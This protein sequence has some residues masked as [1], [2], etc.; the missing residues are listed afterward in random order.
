MSIYLEQ[1][2]LQK[3]NGLARET[4]ALL[5]DDKAAKQY[6]AASEGSAYID[7]AEKSADIS[8]TPEKY[9][10]LSLK[11][12]RSGMFEKCI[13]ACEKALQ[14]RP[15]FAEAYNNI[16]S[17]HNEMKNW[18]KAIEAC[19]KALEI[20]PEF[21]LARNNLQLAKDSLKDRNN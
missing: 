20:S 2:E 17:A 15:Q 3:L 5:P 16:C 21:E 4:L 8:P 18:D 10:D 13:E 6:L 1:S 14:L 19:E 7:A 11:Y 12:Y 9:L